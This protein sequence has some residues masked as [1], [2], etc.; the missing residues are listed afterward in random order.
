MTSSNALYSIIFGNG[1]L[2]VNYTQDGK[3][4]YLNKGGTGQAARIRLNNVFGLVDG[5]KLCSRLP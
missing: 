5:W 1:E 4:I 2:D 3:H